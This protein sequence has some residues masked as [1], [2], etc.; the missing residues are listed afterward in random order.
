VPKPKSRRLN[1]KTILRD[2]ETIVMLLCD[3]VTPH[4]ITNVLIKYLDE[5]IEHC[6][7]VSVSFERFEKAKENLLKAAEHL[8][9]EL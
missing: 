3:E 5:T 7:E 8:N 6:K 9:P 1:Y 2:W 4:D